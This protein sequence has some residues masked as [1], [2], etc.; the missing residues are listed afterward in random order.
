MAAHRPGDVATSDPLLTTKLA[1]PHGRQ[2][3]VARPRLLARLDAGLAAALILVAA[4]PGFGK[5]TLVAEWAR[6]GGRPVAWL[7]L[8]AADNDPARFA[9]YLVAAIEAAQPGIAAGAHAALQA[10]RDAPLDAVLAALIDALATLPRDLVLVLDDYHAIEARPIHGALATLVANRPSRAHLVIATRADPPLPLA[11]LRARGELVELRAADLRFTPEEAA[12]FLNQSMGL[13]LSA[14]QVAAL[15]ERAEGWIAGLQLAALSLRGRDDPAAFIAAFS[16]T[17]RHILDYLAEEVLDRQA[18]DDRRFLLQTS[19]LERLTADL[20]A[21]LTGRAE[22]QLVLERLDRENLFLIPLDD[23]RRWYRYHHLFADVLRNHLRRASPAL[24]PDLH[25]RAAAWYEGHGLPFEAVEHALAGGDSDRAADLVERLVP[26]LWARREPV[27]LRRWLDAL[28]DDLVRARPRLAMAAAESRL[29]RGRGTLAEPYLDA[30][31]RLLRQESLGEQRGDDPAD[32]AGIAAM[33]SLAAIL[34]EDVQGS[35]AL[36]REALDTLPPSHRLRGLALFSLGAAHWL[37]GD[38]AAADR[39]LAS[40][41]EDAIALGHPYMAQLSLV[42]LAETRLLAGRLPDAVALYERSLA[43]TPVPAGRPDVNGPYVGLGAILYER[44]DLAGADTSLRRGIDLAEQEGNHLVIIAGLLFLAHVQ[45]AQGVAEGASRAMDRAMALAA[46]HGFARLW[47]APSVRAHEVR[48][49]LRQG[50][51]GDA[52]HWARTLHDRPA[53]TPVPGLIREAEQLAVARVLLAQ[54]QPPA[55]RDL[56]AGLIEAAAR[57][58]RARSEMEARTLQALALQALGRPEEAA[59]ALGRALILA[60][61]GGFV[62]TFLDEVP[63]ITP[64]LRAAARDGAAGEYAHRL[65]GALAP[66]TEGGTATVPA[67]RSTQ[68][69]PEPL[70]ERELAVLRLAAEGATNQEIADRAFIA[71]NTVKK[72]LK[73]VFAKLEASSRTEAVARAR[74]LGLL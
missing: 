57:A 56:L 37:E 61:P 36:A 72:H 30:A 54:G 3:L 42:Y 1:M 14:A 52:G 23:E 12:E 65:L 49:W 19:V 16:G 73:N 29:L 63:A 47:I 74:D 34:R 43:L 13:R 17:H 33:R 4:P 28:S 48:L 25:R 5:S 11:R 62:R 35:V 46:E 67:S 69:L 40:A 7:S 2:A 26:A 22:S 60:T 50:R 27:T 18:E 9:R 39:A 44:N 66:R 71:V 15:E 32:L 70:T 24:V 68:P 59:Q 38:I 8:D 20:C 31:E 41:A 55:A 10:A 53:E 51:V 6:R 58:G 45:Q 21:A 64:L